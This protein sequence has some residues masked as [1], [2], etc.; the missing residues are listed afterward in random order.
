MDDIPKQSEINN[1]VAP[2]VAAFYSELGMKL[3]DEN[4]WRNMDH[5][6]SGASDTKGQFRNVL[7]TWWTSTPKQ[8]RTWEYIVEAL[9]SNGMQQNRVAQNIT[10]NTF[11]IFFVWFYSCQFYAT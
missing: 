7:N 4:E 5:Q 1:D 11:K 8:N 9:N 3:I 10:K 2:K 6:Y